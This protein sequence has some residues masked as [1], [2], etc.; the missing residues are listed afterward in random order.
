MLRKPAWVVLPMI[1]FV[2]PLLIGILQRA[3]VYDDPYILMRYGDHLANGMGWR[4]NPDSSTDNAVTSPLYVLLIAAGTTVGGSPEFWSTCIYILA[5]GA[6]GI[7]LASILFHDGRRVGGWIACGLYSL[8]PLLANV[9][10]METSVYLLILIASIWAFQR[11]KWVLLG[12]LLAILGMARPD[13][14][15]LGILLIAWLFVRRRAVALKSLYS[16]VGIGAVWAIV[17]YVITGGLVPST[18]AAKI[19]LRQ[20]DY[21]GGMFGFLDGLRQGGITGLGNVPLGTVERLDVVVLTVTA[22]VGTVLAFRTKRDHAMMMLT[23]S[24]LIV[25]FIYGI[26]LRVPGTFPWYYAPWALW[27]IAGVAVAL[28]EAA[29]YGARQERRYGVVAT[30][31]ALSASAVAAVGLSSTVELGPNEHR[32]D[33]REVAAWIDHDATDPHPTVAT[34][35]IGT[36]GYFSRAH[37]IDYLGLLDPAANNHLR[38][39]DLSWWLPTYQPRVL[40][41]GGGLGGCRTAETS[42]IQ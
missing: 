15:L 28:D 27:V 26:V 10:G 5:W 14:Y 41:H 39:G 42:L 37:I 8:S 11:E 7:A 9:R 16:F 2:G 20:S 36:I 30:A 31:A 40:G 21:W 38:R 33:Y 6:G 25:V 1:A 22:A 24:A 17:S 3:P 34:L 18:V 32:R 23:S 13:G 4:F 35:E 29:R 19:A 12:S